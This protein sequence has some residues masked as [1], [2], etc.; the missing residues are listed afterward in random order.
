MGGGRRVRVGF[1]DRV[2]KKKRTGSGLP[3]VGGGG[4]G[5]PASTGRRVSCAFRPPRRARAGLHQ[6]WLDPAPS[7]AGVPKR[8]GGRRRGARAMERGARAPPLSP[9]RLSPFLPRARA[10]PARA[11]AGHPHP[12]AAARP[13]GGRT[14]PGGERP[15]TAAPAAGARVGGRG[16]RRKKQAGRR[17]ARTRARPARADPGPGCCLPPSSFSAPPRARGARPQ[18]APSARP[19]AGGTLCSARPT[20]PGRGGGRGLGQDGGSHCG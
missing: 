20:H 3:R 10:G 16:K 9:F 18:L 1:L 4:R 15:E 13:D 14:G 17:R 11:P 6:G 7:R 2:R 12:P 8:V 19:P 5:P